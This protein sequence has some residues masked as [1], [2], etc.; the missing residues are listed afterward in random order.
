MNCPKCNKPNRDKAVFCKYCGAS[1]ITKS[2]APLQALVGMKEVKNQLQDI[3]NTCEQLALR[4][5]KTGVKI[6]LGMDMVI[7]GN[8]GTGKSKVVEVLQHLLYSTGIIK[9]PKAMIVDAVDWENFSRS[10]T[11][12]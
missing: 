3:V 1:V 5:K 2:N 11:R 9:N 4:A 12:T 10:G 7:V 8:T 6:R